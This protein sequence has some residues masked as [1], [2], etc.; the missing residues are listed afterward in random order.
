MR[1]RWQRFVHMPDQERAKLLALVFAGIIISLLYFLGATSLYLRARYLRPEIP[2][3]Q[4]TS[5]PSPTEEASATPTASA[6][7]FPTMTPENDHQGP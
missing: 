3:A 2:L 7:L 1:E 5:P 6:T 4:A